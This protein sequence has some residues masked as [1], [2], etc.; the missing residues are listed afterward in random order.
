M[1]WIMQISLWVHIIIFL[2]QSAFGF[3]EPPV[4]IK[5]CLVEIV[6]DYSRKRKNVFR[7]TTYTESVYLLQAEDKGTMMS[8]IQAI[9]TNNS[10]DHDVSF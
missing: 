10:P 8:W 3:E 1:V 7:L 6:H 2:Q 9:K 4:S 5:S